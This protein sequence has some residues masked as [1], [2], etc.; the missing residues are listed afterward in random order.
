MKQLE[1]ASKQLSLF[2]CTS[3]CALLL[4]TGCAGPK[5]MTSRLS[6]SRV[7]M[8]LPNNASVS[9]ES[10]SQSRSYT[11]QSTALRQDLA[12]KLVSRR[13][14]TGAEIEGGT[15]NGLKLVIDVTHVGRA[16][17]KVRAFG[18]WGWKS[19]INGP[20]STSIVLA[21]GKLL[22]ADNSVLATIS[23][24]RYGGGGILGAGGWLTCGENSMIQALRGWVAEDICH[25]LKKSPREETSK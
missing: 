11:E 25:S 18:R 24:Q 7:W 23:E 20:R 4:T 21:E 3:V 15:D 8:S 12:S 22:S 16:G 5:A 13:I 19:K 17:W 6:Q 2:A 10:N 1:M 14:F 9:I